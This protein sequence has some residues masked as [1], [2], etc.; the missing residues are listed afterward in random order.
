ML[1]AQLAAL[2]RAWSRRRASVKCEARPRAPQAR[3]QPDRRSGG[4]AGGRSRG[5]DSA[6]VSSV[7]ESSTPQPNERTRITLHHP[8]LLANEHRHSLAGLRSKQRLSE[9]APQSRRLAKQA[10][11]LPTPIPFPPTGSR[12]ELPLRIGL[13]REKPL[14]RRAKA[15]RQGGV[16][17]RR[18]STR[19]AIPDGGR[20]STEGSATG[21][22]TQNRRTH[23]VLTS[24]APC[25]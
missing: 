16:G 19:F 8:T 4:G 10:T 24:R 21:V 9:S 25:R 11:T 23:A 3:T 5:V 14:P 20:P 6:K 12:S 7:R 18:A 2:L 15:R 1:S 22:G 13:S 17:A